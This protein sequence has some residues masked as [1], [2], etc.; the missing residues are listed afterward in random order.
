M[1]RSASIADM[2]FAFIRKVCETSVIKPKE[3]KERVRSEKIDRV[4]TGK[5][6]AIPL[7]ILIMALVFFLTFFLIGP[8][9]QDLLQNGIDLL[10]EGAQQGMEA[11]HVNSTIQSLILDGIFSSVWKLSARKP[12]LMKPPTLPYRSAK[13]RKPARRS[14]SCPCTTPPLP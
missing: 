10:K 3:S 4:L 8:F 1:D 5:H 7:F 12:S 11:V 2:R 9:F 6:T 13:P 14:S